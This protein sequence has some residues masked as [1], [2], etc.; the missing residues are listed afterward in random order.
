[1][2]D[3]Q[4]QI[5]SRML[6]QSWILEEGDQAGERQSAEGSL[7]LCRR[8]AGRVLFRGDRVGNA[9]SAP[10][11]PKDGWN[12]SLGKG[13]LR[14]TTF[15]SPYEYLWTKIALEKR[16]GATGVAYDAALSLLDLKDG[17]SPTIG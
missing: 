14:E 9:N 10:L 6:T 13:R 17:V 7:L 15:L 2:S 11:L 12:V 8:L 16:D 3:R 1:M 4:D 5:Y